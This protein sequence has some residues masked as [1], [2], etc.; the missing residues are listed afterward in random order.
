MKLEEGK[1][2][3][4]TLCLGYRQIKKI[5]GSTKIVTSDICNFFQDAKTTIGRR[6]LTRAYDRYFE[7]VGATGEHSL[8]TN[9]T[10]LNDGSWRTRA[11]DCSK[12]QHREVPFVLESW[13]EPNSRYADDDD[14]HARDYFEW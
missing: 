8:A 14:L 4:D 1:V 13:Y 5:E 7:E 12:Y 6:R 3:F 10:N 9:Q 11:T 2:Y